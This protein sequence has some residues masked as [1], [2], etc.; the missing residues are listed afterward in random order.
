VHIHLRLHLIILA[1]GVL[2]LA[3]AALAQPPPTPT[4]PPVVVESGRGI[5]ERTRSDQEE[6]A[7]SSAGCPGAPAWSWV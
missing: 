6:P 3:G 4:L 1:V 7:R 2:G 5:D